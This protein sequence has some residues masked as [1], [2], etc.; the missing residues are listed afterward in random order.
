MDELGKEGP[1]ARQILELAL[2]QRSALPVLV[3]QELIRSEA[4]KCGL[5]PLIVTS[6][7]PDFYKQWPLIPAAGR[8][9][10]PALVMNTGQHFDS[11][12]G[13]GLDEFGIRKRLAID[14]QIRGDLSEKTSEVVL[15][16]KLVAAYLSGE[17]PDKVFLP[18]VHGDTH[19]AGIVPLGWMFATNQKAAQNEAGLRAMSPSFRNVK[20][21]RRFISDQL[22]ARKWAI[23]RTE[24]FP[25][26]YDTFIGGA[27]CHHHFAPTGLNRENLEREGYLARNIPVVGNSIVE[28]LREKMKRGPSV[29][30]FSDMPALE[31][32]EWVRVDVH[33]RENM[34]GDRFRAIV[35]GVKRLV[36]AGENVVFI[37]MNAN[38]FA[39]EQ[40]G[41][42]PEIERLKERK[43]FLYTPLWREYGQ[44]VEFLTSGRC[45]AILT[46]SG[47][48][49]EELNELRRGPACITCRFSTD[50]PESV[51]EGRSNILA[52]PISGE[53][54]GGFV[55]LALGGRTAGGRRR[56]YGKDPSDRIM[57]FLKRRKGEF[58]F[59][60]AHERA[61]VKYAKLSQGRRFFL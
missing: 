45:S 1:A 32:G 37:E 50:R 6:T 29:S 59:E 17:F 36:D 39:I 53:Y 27:A 61:G 46:D 52:P 49:Q 57:R 3:D 42:G 35:S 22:D 56:L 10:M 24:P 9:G 26:Q 5:V 60:W 38:R 43:N 55:R 51:F 7:K 28:A 44:V 14:L 4:Q 30:V 20:D 41:L 13:H 48:M 11:L 34:L 54:L 47:S 16:L 8:A 58:P 23:N 33:R 31:K 25:E 2:P 12:L 40:E 18:I 15:K 19:A 21:Q